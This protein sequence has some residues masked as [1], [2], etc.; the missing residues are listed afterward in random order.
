MLG[1]SRIWIIG[2][3]CIIL[4]RM[5][6]RRRHIGVCPLRTYIH[7]LDCHLGTEDLAAAFVL[8]KSRLLGDALCDDRLALAFPLCR[9]L[10][11]GG[12]PGGPRIGSSALLGAGAS[13][14][15]MNGACFTGVGVALVGSGMLLPHGSDGS[16]TAGLAIHLGLVLR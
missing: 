14:G 5:G 13:P 4:H 12:G 6:L 2:V 3:A 7:A 11:G 10:G 16:G 8:P 1:M 15:G 9:E